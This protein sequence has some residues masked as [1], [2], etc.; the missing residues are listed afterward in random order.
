MGGKQRVD[1]ASLS[2][3][4]YR[5]SAATKLRNVNIYNLSVTQCDIYFANFAY[6]NNG[7]SFTIVAFLPLFALHVQTKAHDEDTKAVLENV[8][9]F[10]TIFAYSSALPSMDP[11]FPAYPIFALLSFFLVLI[12]LPWHLQAWNSGTCL[13][14]IWVAAGCLNQFINSIVWHNNAIDWA[15]LW[16]DIC[17]MFSPLT[18]EDTLIMGHQRHV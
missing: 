10:Y 14:M 15:P 6:I 13:Y 11:T 8:D 5:G 1:K 9:I 18:L 17:K 3:L 7:W 4:I 12:P 16:C 2:V